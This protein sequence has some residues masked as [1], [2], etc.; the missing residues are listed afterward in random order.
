MATVAVVTR[1]E[2]PQAMREFLHKRGYHEI[3]CVHPPRDGRDIKKDRF[4][5]ATDAWV[6]ILSQCG[7]KPALVI[8]VFKRTY[9]PEFFRI[10]QENNIPVWQPT[11]DQ[12]VTPAKWC[13][14]TEIVE[15]EVTIHRKPVM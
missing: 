13:G 5:H 4:H 10:A 1:H 8:V 3:V 6:N 9:M 7:K 14:F 15:V 11:V 2:M 12:T